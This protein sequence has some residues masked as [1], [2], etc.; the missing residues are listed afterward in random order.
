M[1]SMKKLQM[2]NLDEFSSFFEIMEKSFPSIER[3]TYEDQLA[4][5]E[6]Q[7]YKIIGLKDS[8]NKVRA[9]IAIWNFEDFNFIEHFAVDDTLR[10]QGI[11]TYILNECI[12]SMGDK[13]VLLEVELPEDDISKRRINFYKRC[14]FSFNSY[15][16]MQPSLQKG[17]PL[18]PLRIMSYPENLNETDFYKFKDVLYKKVY[19]VDLSEEIEAV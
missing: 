15:A 5:L 9:F 8:N 16:Y 10:S 4:L 7:Y 11:G 13:P 12:K 3:R 18:L 1:N 6:D 14:G 2:I 17:Y 19:K